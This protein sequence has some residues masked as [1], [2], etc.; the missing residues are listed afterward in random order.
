LLWNFGLGREKLHSDSI[1]SSCH[2]LQQGLS[3]L[4]M[5]SFSI[6]VGLFGARSNFWRNLRGKGA[7]KVNSYLMLNKTSISSW[8]SISSLPSRPTTVQTGE[9]ELRGFCF[10]LCFGLVLAFCFEEPRGMVPME[11]HAYVQ[12]HWTCFV[13]QSH[14][15]WRG[16][17]LLTELGN[18][19]TLQPTLKPS[20]EQT[21]NYRLWGGNCARYMQCMCGRGI[22]EVTHI[23]WL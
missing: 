4:M 20:D 19:K 9:E 13:I 23:F 2:G 5:V 17:Y 7:G 18:D 10:R 12:G 21:I 16:C 8:G 11:R 3:W 14:T 6:E 22:P 15:L 1:S